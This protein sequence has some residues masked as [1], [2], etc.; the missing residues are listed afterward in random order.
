[1]EDIKVLLS[2][3]YIEITITPETELIKKYNWDILHKF[4]KTNY[5]DMYKKINTKILNKKYKNL[6]LDKLENLYNDIDKYVRSTNNFIEL[7]KK[8]IDNLIEETESKDSNTLYNSYY[9]TIYSKDDFENIENEFKY[10][11]HPLIDTSYTINYGLF[12]ALN[13]TNSISVS[14]DQEYI[15]TLIIIKCGNDYSNVIIPKEDLGIVKTK[16]PGTNLGIVMLYNNKTKINKISDNIDLNEMKTICDKNKELTKF[17]MSSMVKKY[18][19][20]K[21]SKNYIVDKEKPIKSAVVYFNKNNLSDFSNFLNGKLYKL[22]TPF[23]L[24]IISSLYSSISKNKEIKEEYLKYILSTIGINYSH[25]KEIS[26]YYKDILENVYIVGKTLNKKNS[27]ILNKELTVY[28]FKNKCSLNYDI[29]YTK[30]IM[31]KDK[32]INYP[33]YMN[34]GLVWEDKGS[35]KLIKSIPLSVKS[36][37]NIYDLDFI[38]FVVEDVYIFKFDNVDAFI[39]EDTIVLLNGNIKFDKISTFNNSIYYYFTVTN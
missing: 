13:S 33:L 6:S 24:K 8:N 39:S 37:Y 29:Y 14:S 22:I 20:D 3:S 18:S 5:E 25:D 12:M 15:K 9:G 19:Y 36:K 26:K 7:T 4:S 11:S 31:L 38:R 35:E 16:I 27:I 30:K 10:M 17:F 23:N 2:N 1:M 21:E 32:C 28:N 34:Y